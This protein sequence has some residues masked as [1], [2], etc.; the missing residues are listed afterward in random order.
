MEKKICAGEVRPAAPLSFAKHGKF[1]KN[2]K[3]LLSRPGV[4]NE[5]RSRPEIGV[6]EL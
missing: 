2:G 3:S 1:Q 5:P 6:E 4:D